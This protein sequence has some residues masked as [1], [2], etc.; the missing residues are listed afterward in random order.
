MLATAKQSEYLMIHFFNGRGTIIGIIG[1]FAQG[2][3][4]NPPGVRSLCSKILSIHSF[5]K[6]LLRN[7]QCQDWTRFWRFKTFKKQPLPSEGDLPSLSK[8]H[9][10][11][12][13][14]A[15]KWRATL[16]EGLLLIL[17]SESTPTVYTVLIS[18]M[19]IKIINETRVLFISM[20]SI[21][22]VIS[23]KK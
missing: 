5:K 15:L 7:S 12:G 23:L 21:R 19:Y 4:F 16:P 13:Q 6:C 1:K 22:N 18:T 3:R 9:W 2:N 17:F 20:M 10:W 14:L 11:G 8:C